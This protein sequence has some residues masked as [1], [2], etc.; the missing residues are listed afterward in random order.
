MNMRAI[1]V[2]STLIITNIT[3]NITHAHTHLTHIDEHKGQRVLN[4]TEKEFH[5]TSKIESWVGPIPV[6]WKKKK[7]YG[8]Q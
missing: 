3:Y 6:K 7:R 8:V 1:V 2:R 4:G 5:T